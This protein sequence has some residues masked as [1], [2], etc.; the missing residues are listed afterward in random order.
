MSL[1]NKLGILFSVLAIGAVPAYYAFARASNSSRSANLI[2][3]NSPSNNSQNTNALP[4]T[5]IA[6]NSGAITLE[7][8]TT[9]VLLA[10]VSPTNPAI[11]SI[12][13][14]VKAMPPNQRLF[15]VLRG[16]R[17][18][19]PPGTLYHLFLDLPEGA[20]PDI[21]TPP[22]QLAGNLNFF[23]FV[24]DDAKAFRSFDITS[25]SHDLL[26]RG[27][28]TRETSLTIVPAH[29]PEEGATPVIGRIE[30]LV[31]PRS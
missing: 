29:P 28:L 31:Q 11:G 21:K 14:E 25:L 10:D 19:K 26:N 3:L 5:I 27:L 15:L 30:I 12:V 8:G 20:A 13:A 6:K 1:N 7:S 17:A 22:P 9:R 18:D 2:A 24:N 16:L 23:N 4:S